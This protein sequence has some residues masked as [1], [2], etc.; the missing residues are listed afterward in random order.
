MVCSPRGHQ[1]LIG[2]CSHRQ[3]VLVLVKKRTDKSTCVL[4]ANRFSA[5]SFT[6][7]ES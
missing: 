3:D 2:L 4:S 7:E 6:G 1:R 5:D